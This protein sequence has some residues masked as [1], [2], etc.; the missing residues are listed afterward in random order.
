MRDGIISPTFVLSRVHPNDPN[1]PRPGG[2]DLVHVDAYRLD[3]A[4]DVD[5][6]DL[7]DTVDTC[8]T[9]VEWGTDKV[10]HLSDSRLVI[11][12]VRARGTQDAPGSADPA[13][14]VEAAD[15]EGP[16]DLGGPV[17]SGGSG[18][19]GAAAPPSAMDVIRALND[20]WESADQLSDEPRTVIVR[21]YG[22]R[23]ENPLRL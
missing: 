21:G 10:E 13:A 4:A 6:I 19:G 1:G 20:E 9:V 2:P 12:I 15:G 3:S 22:P 23:W 17:L 7:E 16:V 11:D 5:D 14:G 8:V 18:S